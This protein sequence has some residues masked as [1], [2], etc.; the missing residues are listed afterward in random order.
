MWLILMRKTVF[1]N[2]CPVSLVWPKK[3]F[4]SKSTFS[5]GFAPF[6]TFEKKLSAYFLTYFYDSHVFQ[7]KC[8]VSIIFRKNAYKYRK[9]LFSCMWLILRRK[10]IFFNIC[11]ISLVWPKKVVSIKSKHFFRISHY[12]LVK[13]NF[14]SDSK[15][16]SESH[17]V[18]QKDNFSVNFHEN[19]CKI[20]AK[21]NLAVCGLFW[22][23]KSFSSIF[24]PFHLFDKKKVV[25]I[26]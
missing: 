11:P 23:G 13:N 3:F 24:I 10:T 20:P 6:Q 5:S 25:S 15:L 21:L 14:L 9:I 19:A 18:D 12:S 26:K 1:V 2:I 17:F 4:H 16:L 7:T 22:G 8:E